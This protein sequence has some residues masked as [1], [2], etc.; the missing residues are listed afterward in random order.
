MHQF[1]TALENRDQT[2]REINEL[3]YLE[4]HSEKELSRIE[5]NE[6][7]QKVKENFVVA[8]HDL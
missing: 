1:C 6:D 3:K 5:E 8:C 7:K 2:E 4:H